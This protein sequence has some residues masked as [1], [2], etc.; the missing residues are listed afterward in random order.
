MSEFDELRT[1]I[2]VADAGSF[3][4][5]ASQLGASKAATSR[6]IAE[7]EARLGVRLLQ[8]TTRRLSLTDEGRLFLER[9]RQVLADLA[10]AEAEITSR[11]ADPTGLLRVNAPFTFGIGH[12]APL[13]G[14]FRERHPKVTLDVTL[15]D[16]FVDL[17]EEG[18]DLAVRI[19]RQPAA[20]LVSRR[21]ASTRL[22]LCAAPSYLRRHGRPGH[23]SE[24]REHTIASYAFLASGDTW[25]F[26]GPDGP[27][28]IQTTPSIRTN[29][30]NTCRAIALAGHAVV[31]QPTFLV[32]ED[33]A[34]GRLVELLPRWRSHELGV[35]AIYVT[36]RHVAPKVRALID[37]LVASFR[38][39]KWPG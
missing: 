22:V 5:A 20:T 33:L 31:L 34:S 27:V 28:E 25:H 12:L 2:A 36:R 37:F 4:R 10:E 13:W 26:D 1:F 35:F 17:V 19:T 3:V 39:P 9:S 32:G 7:L 11:R 8:R 16:R 15:S 6:R 24:L 38:R 23:P 18:F 21:L 14:E 29:N 30:G